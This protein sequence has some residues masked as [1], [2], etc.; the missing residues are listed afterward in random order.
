MMIRKRRRTVKNHRGFTLIELLV[1]IAI[2]AILAA[3]L[4]PVFAQ[5]RTKARQTSDL[6]NIKQLNTAIL[7]YV[8]DYDE[9]MPCAGMSHNGLYY[10]WYVSMAP[11]I[12][13]NQIFVSP[14]YSFQWTS[15]DFPTWAWDYMVQAGAV[16]DAN[17]VYSIKISYGANGANDWSWVNTCGGILQN[18]TDNSQGVGHKGP[19]APSWELSSLS[20]ID[21]PAETVLLTNAK[22]P[23]LWAVSD[24]GLLVNGQ[25][26][27][28]ETS[29]GYFTWTS[30]DPLVIGAFN[31]QNNIGFVDGHAKSRRMYTTCPH[32][33]TTL[34][35]A[36]YDPIASCRH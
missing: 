17:G 36:K 29:V 1:V 26:P 23:D 18:W 31:G 7:M 19:M 15:N 21:L 4:F 16:K 25:Q 12:K 34:D 24:M 14:Q 27:C 5:A 32:E 6:S 28:G 2:I 20:S 3:I 30:I 8:Q 9:E 11:Y 35:D 13:N 10:P 22:F 33:L